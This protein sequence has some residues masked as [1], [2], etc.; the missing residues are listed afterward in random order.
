MWQLVLGLCSLTPLCFPLQTPQPIAFW[1]KDTEGV[2][3]GPPRDPA[4]HG[5]K[6]EPHMSAK[7]TW[8]FTHPL[9]APFLPLPQFLTCRCSLG[10]FCEQTVCTEVLVSEPA[11]E[12]SS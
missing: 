2:L 9:L 5:G 12:G 10:S 11:L 6:T 7:V 8:S 1:W 4:P 3:C